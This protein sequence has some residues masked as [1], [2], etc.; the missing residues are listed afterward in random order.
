M[1]S[2]DED[3]PLS[4]V[5]VNQGT[6][7][8]REKADVSP[9]SKSNPWSLFPAA[10]AA[11]AKTSVSVLL[12]AGLTYGGYFL[13]SKRHEEQLQT[14]KAELLEVKRAQESSCRQSRV[15]ELLLNLTRE[16]MAIAGRVQQINGDV[17]VL[18]SKTK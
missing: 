4:L 5:N 13:G 15:D 16:Q 14:V 18:L 11:R 2:G 12:L 6:P 10:E 9:S 7:I 1:S 3:P 17:Q 8:I